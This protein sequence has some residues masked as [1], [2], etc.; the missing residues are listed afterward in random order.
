M[1]IQYS[2]LSKEIREDLSIMKD[3][4]SRMHDE[5]QDITKGVSGIQMSEISPSSLKVNSQSSFILIGRAT[6]AHFYIT[7]TLLHS[8]LTRRSYRTSENY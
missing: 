6:F 5:L 1:L 7:S 4:A 2:K 8:R 3:S